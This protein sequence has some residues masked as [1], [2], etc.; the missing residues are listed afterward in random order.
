MYRMM[1]VREILGGNGT[2]GFSDALDHKKDYCGEV[3]S[4][5]YPQSKWK[6]RVND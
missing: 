5:R 2:G 4:K 3:V 1:R 6:N